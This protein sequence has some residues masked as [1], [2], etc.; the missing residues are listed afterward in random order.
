[1]AH[2]RLA[3][4][5]PTNG[6]SSPRAAQV[7]HPV[8]LTSGRQQSFIANWPEKVVTAC[9]SRLEQPFLGFGKR[10]PGIL[11]R[12]VW[13]CKTGRLALRCSPF[14]FPRGS[15]RLRR[16][17]HTPL[18]TLFCK[19]RQRCF[20]AMNLYKPVTGGHGG[21]PVRTGSLWRSG[22]RARRRTSVCCRIRSS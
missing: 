12:P 16:G 7:P 21:A 15:R 1:M 14:W 20:R 11:T 10:P 2:L 6:R 9:N 4:L 8:L 3:S 18:P 5:Q 22:G 19:I 13:H 17:C